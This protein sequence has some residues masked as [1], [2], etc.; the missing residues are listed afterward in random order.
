MA[1]SLPRKRSVSWIHGR[2]FHASRI[3]PEFLGDDKMTDNVMALV[4]K[5]GPQKK[6][7]GKK[8]QIFRKREAAASKARPKRIVNQW[9]PF[10][11][12]VDMDP[13]EM[14]DEIDKFVAEAGWTQSRNVPDPNLDRAIVK[15][16]SILKTGIPFPL[17]QTFFNDFDQDGSDNILQ[18]FEIFKQQDYVQARVESMKELISRR[19]ALPLKIPQDVLIKGD[20]LPSITDRKYKTI[21]PVENDGIIKQRRVQAAP[22]ATDYILSQC[23]SEYKRAPWMFHFTNQVIRGFALRNLDQDCPPELTI[24][25]EVQDGWY[26]VSAAW[27]KM[28]CDGQREFIP[29][30]VAYVTANDEIIIETEDMYNASKKDWIREFTPIDAM[31]IDIA[32]RMLMDNDIL[33]SM[34]SG[35]Q[36][37][38]Y[39]EAIIN[40]FGHI[41]TNDVLARNLSRILVFLT[42]LID[43]PQIYHEKIIRQDYDG[44]MLIHLDYDTLLPEVFGEPN[45]D[46]TPVMKKIKHVRRCIE[47]KYYDLLKQNDPVVRRRMN[48]RRLQLNQRTSVSLEDTRV[49]LPAVLPDVVGPILSRRRATTILAPG[50]FQKLRELITQMTPSYCS[51][52][53][54][55]VFENYYASIGGEPPQHLKFCDNDCFGKH[56]FK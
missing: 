41:T 56:V 50:L 9:F 23:E 24:P 51:E 13:D 4:K 37:E 6:L 10:R 39:V 49:A 26:K 14:V 32:K 27:Y 52:C 12:F 31:S 8:A 48:P 21:I 29:G 47:N 19:Q 15:L 33:K 43:E 16:F 17:V 53:H 25:V 45:V 42:I 54:K 34:D 35:R 3:V 36:L 55:E 44:D 30:G 2:A 1:F 46:V 38:L 18:Y 22:F 5:K 40:S 7:R 11:H 20:I 28:A